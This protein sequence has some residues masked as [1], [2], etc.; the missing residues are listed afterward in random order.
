MAPWRKYL[1][2]FSN[3]SINGI[4]HYMLVVSGISNPCFNLLYNNLFISFAKESIRLRSFPA[5]MCSRC[6][7][8]H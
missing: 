2:Y 3:E 6:C 8:V 5:G 1:R 4:Y 7:I